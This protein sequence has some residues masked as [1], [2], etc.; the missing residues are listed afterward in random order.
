MKLADTIISEDE[1]PS[2]DHAVIEVYVPKA[3]KLSPSAP[4]P[5]RRGRRLDV[6]GI[7][8]RSLPNP[9]AYSAPEVKTRVSR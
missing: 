9:A 7:L 5:V 1:R 2:P 8:A 4:I 3:N 6:D